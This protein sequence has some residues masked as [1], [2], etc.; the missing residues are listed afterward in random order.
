MTSRLGIK[1]IKAEDYATLC[2]KNQKKINI[3]FQLDFLSRY[4]TR[5]IKI[6]GDKGTLLWESNSK[7]PE[8]MTVK[9][10]GNNKVIKIFFNKKIL[11]TDY[12]YQEMLKDFVYKRKYLQTV[13]EA[14]DILNLAL[15]A[16]S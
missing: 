2:F 4:K 1:K 13:N 9:F 12:V 3:L 14:Y 11:H 7:N 8:L 5:G 6:V 10:L 16:R 15:I